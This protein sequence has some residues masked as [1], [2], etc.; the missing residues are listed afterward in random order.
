MKKKGIIKTNEA[1]TLFNVFSVL[2][3]VQDHLKGIYS[4]NVESL[5]LNSFRI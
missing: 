3:N 2:L 4:E 5:K 1:L